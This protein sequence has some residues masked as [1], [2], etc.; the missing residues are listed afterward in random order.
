MIPNRCLAALPVLLALFAS[1]AAHAQAGLPTQTWPAGTQLADWNRGGR[2]TTFH[3][4]LLYLGGTDGQGTQVYDISNPTSPQLRCNDPRSSNGHT[5]QKIGDLFFRQ[6]LSGDARPAGANPFVSLANPCNRVAWTTPIHDFP[7][8]SGIDYVEGWIESYPYWFGES[9]WDARIGW[10]P[11]AGGT[12][13]NAVAGINAQNKFRIGNLLFVTP[14]D[15]QN[16]VAVFDIGTPGTPR[17]LDTLPGNF[18]QYTTSWQ[19]WRHYLVMMFGDDTNGPQSNANTLVVDFSNPSDLRVAHAIPYEVMPGRYVHFQDQYAFAGRGT[20]G[21]KYDMVNRTVVRRYDAP[22]GAW[23]SDFQWIP[24]GHL[25][26]VSGSEVDGSRSFLY[27]HT[28]GRDTTAPTVGWHVPTANAVNQPRSSAIGLVINEQL[29]STT[30]NET[31]IRLIGPG[32]AQVPAVIMHTSWDVVNIVPAQALAADATYEVRLVGGGVEDVAGN[33]VAPFNFFFST[34]ATVESGPTITAFTHA[35]ATPVTQNAAVQFAVAATGA[36]E[37]QF[38]WGDGAAG[39]WQAGAS[40]EHAYATPGQYTAQVQARNGAGQTAT[41]TRVLVV[42]EAAATAARSSSTIVVH[43]TRRE[44]WSSNPDHGTV[45]VLNAASNARIGEVTV[46]AH[47]AGVAVD[48]AGRVWVA[49]RD[50]DTLSRID[51]ATRAVT[52]TLALDYGDRPVA[53]VFAADGTTGYVALAGGGEIARFSTSSNAVEARLAVGPHVQALALAADGSRLFA[54]RMVSGADG[55]VWRVA[56]PAFAAAQTVSLAADTTTADSGTAGRGVPNYLGALAA[57]NDGTRV[58]YAA[59]KDNVSRGTFREANALTF[60]TTVRTIVGQIDGGAGEIAAARLDL[61]DSSRPSALALSPGSSHLFVAL[62]GNNR[63][64]ALDPWNRREVARVDV[65]LA[66]Q[67]LAFDAVTGKLFVQNFLGRSI[68]VVDAAALVTSGNPAM[69]VA[70]TA[71]ANALEP[72]SATVLAGKRAFYNAADVRMSNSGYIAC[73]TCHVDGREDGRIWDFTQLGEGLRNTTS[74]RGVAG[75]GHGLMHWSGNFDE[76][77]DFEIPIRNLF[78]GIGFMDDAAYDTGTRA[79]PLGL[80]KAGTSAA[81]DAIAAYVATLDAFDRS[82]HRSPTGA[83]T[84]DGVAGR[85]LFVASGCAAC[86]AGAAYS[87]SPQNRRHDVGT[88]TAASGK[89]LNQPLASLD[90]PTLRGVFGTAPYFHDGSAATL[91]AVLARDTGGRH[92]NAAASTPAERAQLVAFL[93]QIDGSEPA[94]APPP[95]LELFK[96]GFE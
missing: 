12:N 96:D 29:D 7:L 91:E 78:G 83:L 62:E 10:W 36:A 81:L 2:I 1:P 94:M 5:W 47:P 26:L 60:E 55:T 52:A 67:G 6:Y 69:T 86:H 53:I 76:V 4:G 22:S 93:L 38:T 58:F 42:R 71:A 37:Y 88:I 82:P 13:V 64:L 85:A 89:R 80:P 19:V 32:G 72:L 48:G 34:G 49:N 54:S 59:K 95:A 15:G 40:A 8:T 87:D 17:L 92:G 51:A 45:T 65:G 23:L 18:K 73:A 63:V 57:S 9:I 66:P 31:N 84:A 20:H 24:L 50:A 79:Q 70:A 14:G 3:R 41:A 39:A 90:T 30:V 56:L 68:S 28:D 77:Q 27:T 43:P 16:G 61:D 44:V 35:P 21:V 74:L 46:G 11:T 25:L 33:A 75:L